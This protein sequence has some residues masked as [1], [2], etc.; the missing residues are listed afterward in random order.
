[1]KKMIMLLALLPLLYCSRMP[2]IRYFTINY[3]FEKTSDTKYDVLFVKNFK[4][5]PIYN[6]DKLVY[7]VSDYEIKFDHYRRWV[8]TPAEML[9]VQTLNDLRKSG[10]FNW[11]T[12]VLPRQKDFLRLEGM[13]LQFE[14]TQQ[15][16]QRYANIKVLFS[17]HENETDDLRWNKELGANVLIDSPDSEGI[18]KATSQAVKLTMEQLVDELINL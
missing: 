11:V 5:E 12:D 15:N 17:L 9:S 2:E 16:G 13:V 14:E 7:R 8:L 10:L 6:S 3:E 4:T 1:M 18:V